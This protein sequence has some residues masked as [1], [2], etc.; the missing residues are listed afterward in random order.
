MGYRSLHMTMAT[1]KEVFQRYLPVY[2]KSSKS[3][4]QA[5]LDT[6]CEVTHFH[7]K[8][9]IRKF[10]QL[11]MGLAGGNHRRGRRTVYG[12]D[13]IA[14]L[15][16]IWEAASELC[17]ELLHPVIG[18]YVAVM[19]RD[20]QWHH[21]AGTTD[22]LLQMSEG[23]VKAKTGQFMKARHKRHGLSS[24][25]PSALKNIIPI[26]IGEWSGKPPGFGQIDTVAHCGS[27]LLGDMVFTVNYTD[28]ATLWHGLS[29][30]WNKGQNATQKSIE[31]I[32]NRLPF[33]LLGI[34]P[35]TGSEF[36][37]WHLKG[38]CDQESIELTRS[39]PNHKNDNAYVEQ[40]NGHVIRRFLGY[41][42]FDVKETVEI[43]NQIYQ[44]L[45]L[46][47]NHFVPSRKCVAKTRIGARYKRQYDKAQ[48]P[49]ARVLAH[50]D[51]ND[52]T[53]KNL[54]E[55]H[56]KLNPL[57]LKQEVDKLTLELIKIQRQN[58]NSEISGIIDLGN[59]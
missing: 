18:D 6:V 38:W 11:Q 25:S 32:K 33:R 1:K 35:D 34:H 31:L 8:A 44:K 42:R 9:A 53:K 41:T 28:I 7:R 22:K 45:E 40:K 29:A 47:L 30:Q 15:K 55:I 37:N 49:Y 59:H 4:K 52:E 57:I 58:G 12:P 50:K 10:H 43:I 17:G 20:G 19:R 23:T 14:A 24:T 21:R 3:N 16:E 36:I 51:V 2:L 39:R 13:V 5:I 56:S 26:I 46:Y 54:R 48:T 27:S